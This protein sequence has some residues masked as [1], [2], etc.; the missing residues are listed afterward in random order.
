[1]NVS[2]I[3][4]LA[5]LITIGLL[6]PRLTSLRWPRVPSLDL[7]VAA[8]G[9]LV[10]L[11]FV[12][13]PGIDFLDRLALGAVAP[14][15][16]LAIGWIGATLGARFEWRHVRRIPRGAWLVAALSG[17]ATL[18]AVA[19]TAWLAMRLVPALSAAWTPRFP[20]IVTLG[21]LAAASGPGAVALVVRAVGMPSR[22]ARAIVRAATLETACA[23]LAMTVPFALHRRGGPALAWLA[24]VVLAAGSGALVGLT[25]AWLTRLGTLAR[26]DVGFA[27][28]VTLLFGAGI[29]TAAGIPPFV[30]CF[31]ATVLIVNVSPERRAVRAVLVG[32]ERPIYA[33]LLI[34]A[35][36]LLSAPTVWILLVVP[37]LFGVRA[38]VKWAV[39]HYGRAPL[40]LARSRDL[41][42][43]TIAQGGAVVALGVSYALLYGGSGGA[44]LMTIVLLV[45]AAQLAAPP[46]LAF[47]LRAS[48]IEPTSATMPE[49]SAPLTQPTA[50]PELSA[51]VP[52]EW[53]R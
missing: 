42:V 33:V 45:A 46:L 28:L 15:T 21:A 13:G 51:N 24:W 11:G 1:M 52:A 40:G 10:A 4:A 17:L 8:G 19:V 22:A 3:L 27:V 14:A 7:L 50:P 39:V 41:G 23:V 30:T 25:F 43:G 34:V 20:A 26:A 49:V 9:P 37:V 16:A 36:A 48:P 53:P 18:T 38:V 5:G 47:A 2:P 12:L 6:A 44:L 32:G 29:G 35:G 31:L